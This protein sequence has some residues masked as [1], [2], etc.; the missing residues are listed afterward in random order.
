M[1]EPRMPED[2]PRRMEALRQLSLLDTP[3]EER[4]DR[5]T[6]TVRTLLDVPIALVSLV[7]AQRQWFKSR[8]GLEA[9]QTPRQVSLCGHAILESD[10]LYVPDAGTT[11]ASPTTRSSPARRAFASTPAR[12]C[13]RPTVKGS[14]P[15]ARST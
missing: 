1:I 2:E 13:P 14:A 12:R 8:Q 6:R 4:F 5:I 15:C 10:I 7:D 9:S 3:P 11:P